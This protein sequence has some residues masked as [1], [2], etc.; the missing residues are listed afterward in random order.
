MTDVALVI[1]AGL[2][3]LAGAPH[4]ALMCSASC[5]AAVGRGG[6]QALTAFHLARVTAYA[7]AGA[8]VAASTGALATVAAWSPALRPLWTLLHVAA[9]TLGLW[10][11]WQ[12][13]QP[14]WMSTMG[15]LPRAAAGGSQALASTG[16]WQPVRWMQPTLRAAGVGSLWVAWP[17]G[18]LQS[19]LLV[20]ALTQSPFSGA[21]AM[22]IF[23]ATSATGLLAAPWLWRQMADWGGGGP[24]LANWGT[25][26]AGAVLAGASGWALGHGLWQQVALFC[27]LQ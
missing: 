7:A 19:A 6:P 16:V 24:T 14:A 25:R 4:C 8:L 22:A 2:L 15:R 12:G 9:L 3:G 5:T 1:S 10:L 23:G 13:Q 27:G 11:L 20:A 17:C 21:A 26:A 18:L